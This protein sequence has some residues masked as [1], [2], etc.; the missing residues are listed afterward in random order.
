VDALKDDGGPKVKSMGVKKE[1]NGKK[2]VNPMFPEEEGMRNDN[3]T[4]CCAIF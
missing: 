4:A 1:H 3:K 2:S